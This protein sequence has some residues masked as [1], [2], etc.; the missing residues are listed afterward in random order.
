MSLS[1]S[2]CPSDCPLRSGTQLE[3]TN[4]G[5]AD[6]R[7]PVTPRGAGRLSCP[8]CGSLVSHRSH[9]RGLLE[10]L[11]TYTG[12]RIRR[13]EACSARFV[14]FGTSTAT[15]TDVRRVNQRIVALFLKLILFTVGIL[16]GLAFLVWVWTRIPGA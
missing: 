6:A 15:M 13:C 14:R 4:G 12:G 16:G 1:E 9:R 10:K 8:L 3:E 11:I 7:C 5:A 2:S